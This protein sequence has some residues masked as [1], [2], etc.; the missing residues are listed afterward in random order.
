MYSNLPCALLIIEVCSRING[1]HF[2]LSLTP[3]SSSSSSNL[4]AVVAFH[5]R[6][7]SCNPLSTHGACDSEP[8]KTYPF[9][10]SPFSFAVAVTAAAALK[11]FV[12]LFPPLSLSHYL[13]LLLSL[14]SSRRDRRQS[15]T[16]IA[17]TL[18]T[19]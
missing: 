4:L 16:Y 10:G 15:W 18:H 14:S 12:S 11:V 3:S 19:D 7:P 2:F 5:S 9:C 1:K 8:L 17:D 13:F 6:P